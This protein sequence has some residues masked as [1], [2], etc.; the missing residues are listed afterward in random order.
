MY[1]RDVTT[2]LLAAN[3][4]RVYEFVE[5]TIGKNTIKGRTIGRQGE[6]IDEFTVRRYAGTETGLTDTCSE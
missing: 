6:V 5:L 1:A 2:S 3:A 4:R